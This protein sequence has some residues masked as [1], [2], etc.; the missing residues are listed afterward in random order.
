MSPPQ[1]GET[2]SHRQWQQAGTGVLLAGRVRRWP[3]EALSPGP[4]TGSLRL[5]CPSAPPAAGVSQAS[6]WGQE[7]ELRGRQAPVGGPW[8]P[9]GLG[10]GAGAPHTRQDHWARQVAGG[11]VRPE[12]A[13]PFSSRRGNLQSP[14]VMEA[15]G[16][17]SA[18]TMS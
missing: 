6:P 15:M 7:R 18:L 13:T 17:L 2:L 14:Q 5:S 12:A 9:Q 10:Q 16:V 11:Q 4:W 1:N 3:C 8:Y